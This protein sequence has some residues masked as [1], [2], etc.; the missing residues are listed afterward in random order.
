MYQYLLLLQRNVYRN[1]TN[2]EQLVTQDVPHVIPTWV[3][4]NPGNWRH[5]AVSTK[6][7][8]TLWN[9]EQSNELYYVTKRFVICVVVSWAFRIL[10]VVYFRIMARG[11][12]SGSNMRSV[13][14]RSFSV[15][16]VTL[17]DCW[18]F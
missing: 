16:Y 10:L 7:E 13:A 3:A 1:Y 18:F 17:S 12:M 15:I 9:I 11:N 8:L 4:F 5:L 2:G 6:T 14:A